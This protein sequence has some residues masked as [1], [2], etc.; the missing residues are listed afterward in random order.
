MS[1]A[2]TLE[3]LVDRLK[4][5]P[6]IVSHI[7][8]LLEMGAF[9]QID[10]PEKV[11]QDSLPKSCNKFAL[12]SRDNVMQLIEHL[13]PNFKEWLSST[14]QTSQ[15]KISKKE[16][17][18]TLCFMCHVASDSALPS[19]SWASLQKFVKERWEMYEKRLGSHEP[20][21]GMTFAEWIKSSKASY[22]QVEGTKL[23][24]ITGAAAMTA[25][26]SMKPL[27]DVAC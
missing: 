23:K 24:F 17:L 19:K 21:D 18:Q 1:E 10:Q 8:N 14:S 9:D 11:D 4:D 13:C 6:T 20:Q 25:S 26:A 22:W 7:F 27:W 16:L 2:M 3:N 5:R 12:L 15:G